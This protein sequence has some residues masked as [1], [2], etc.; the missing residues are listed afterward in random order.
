MEQLTF[1][2]CDA[3]ISFMF[4]CP[5]PANLMDED[6]V[7]VSINYRLG[8]F[9]FLSLENDD[10]P[11]NLG[12]WDQRMALVWVRNNIAYFGGD[13]EKVTIMGQSAGSMSVNYHLLSPQSQELEFQRCQSKPRRR[14]VSFQGH[15]NKRGGIK[16][17]K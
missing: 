7:M 5:G 12:L 17:K 11:G 4:I 3:E 15:R 13:P 2:G 10:A 14:K 8:I 16:A 6:I 1:K 9:G